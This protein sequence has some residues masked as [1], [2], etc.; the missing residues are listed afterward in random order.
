MFRLT[1]INPPNGWKAVAWELAIVVAGVLIA[2]AVQQFVDDRSWTI[3]AR[4]ADKS[5]TEEL[6]YHLVSALEWRAVTPCIDQQLENLAATLESS[7]DRLT[8]IQMVSSDLTV[9]VRHPSRNFALNSWDT[10][11]SD[12]AVIHLSNEKRDLFS[13]GKNQG[14]Q[15]NEHQARLASLV[16]Q[17]AV[18]SGSLEL[19]PEIRFVLAEKIAEARS[20]NRLIDRITGQVARRLSPPS[21]N[22]RRDNVADFLRESGTVSHCR[23]ARLPLRGNR[24]LLPS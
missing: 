21:S 9:I 20:V 8:P 13:A 10:A 2:L 18:M 16:G 24:E 6:N 11:V 5:I 14:A 1:R 22:V 15:L 4:Q 19:T 23:Q 12:G 7:P 3:K 17:L